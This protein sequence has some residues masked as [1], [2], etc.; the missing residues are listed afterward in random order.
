MKKIYLCPTAS[1]QPTNLTA[2]CSDTQPP[3]EI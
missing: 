3:I 2:T 1:I